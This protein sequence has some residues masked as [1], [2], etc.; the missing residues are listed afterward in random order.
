M[1]S[2]QDSGEGPSV[3][4]RFM[5]L[6]EVAT[7]LNVSVAQVYALVRSHE[8]PAIKLGGRGVWRIDKGQLEAY[9]EHLHEETREWI[10]TH[11]LASR[12]E[13]SSL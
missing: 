9:I 12:A 6:E 7:Y 4:A 2:T 11:P 3:A 10:R 1:S 8:L 13:E 5:T